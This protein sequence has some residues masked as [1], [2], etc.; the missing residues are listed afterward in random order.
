MG[1]RSIQILY[2]QPSIFHMEKQKV[3]GI[4]DILN[5]GVVIVIARGKSY[6]TVVEIIYVSSLLQ[7]L[8]GDNKNKIA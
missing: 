8:N 1:L 4:A 3:D 5:V 2:E 7:N 6:M